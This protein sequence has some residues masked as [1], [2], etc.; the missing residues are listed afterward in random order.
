M[1]SCLVFAYS[2]IAMSSIAPVP[3]TFHKN[4]FGPRRLRMAKRYPRILWITLLKIRL[5]Q[6]NDQQKQRLALFA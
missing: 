4:G 3:L 6:H 1:A 2:L 5:S